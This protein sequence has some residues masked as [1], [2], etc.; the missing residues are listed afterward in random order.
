MN[1]NQR[2]EMDTRRR[3]PFGPRPRPERR[4]KTNAARAAAR[5][6]RCASIGAAKR[7]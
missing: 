1:E 3:A 4:E 5:M 7:V 6:R 2:Q